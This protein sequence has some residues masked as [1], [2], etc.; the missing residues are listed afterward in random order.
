LHKL[1]LEA[2]NK[3]FQ[4]LKKKIFFSV[5]GSGREKKKKKN[6]SKNKNLTGKNLRLKKPPKLPL[7]ALFSKQIKQS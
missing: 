4:S 6:N 1:E 2:E 7:I 5:P 3:N